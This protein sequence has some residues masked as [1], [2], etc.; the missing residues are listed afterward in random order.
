MC[1]ENM[2]SHGKNGS[3]FQASSVQALPGACCPGFLD[4][5]LI[6]PDP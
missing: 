2:E 3:G 4:F 1:L 6:F 5:R